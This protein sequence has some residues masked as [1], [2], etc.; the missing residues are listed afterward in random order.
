MTGWTHLSDATPTSR[1]QRPCFLCGHLIAIG[2]K[3]IK[4][5]GADDREFVSMSM[6]VEC[7]AETH[8]WDEMDWETF[9]PGDLETRTRESR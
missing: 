5:V 8:D 2:D 1:K 7:E 4:R 6:H 3:Y 9:S